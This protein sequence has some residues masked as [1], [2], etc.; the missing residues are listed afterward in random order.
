[1]SDGPPGLELVEGVVGER[2]LPASEPLQKVDALPGWLGRIASQAS[3]L[4][5]RSIATSKSNK[6]VSSGRMRPVP[7]SRNAVAGSASVGPPVSGRTLAIVTGIPSSRR[8]G[9]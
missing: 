4:T 9:G 3:P 6:G 5:G 7:S 1:M 8:C 2:D